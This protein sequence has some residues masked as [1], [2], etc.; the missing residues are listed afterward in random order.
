M[1]NR[2]LNRFVNLVLLFL[3]ILP[4]AS[5]IADSFDLIIDRY[6][7]LWAA[8]LCLLMWL[9][10]NFQ[11][12]FFPGLLLSALLIYLAYKA[13]PADLRLALTDFFDRITGVYYEHYYAIGSQ[14]P[15]ANAV[16]SHSF[17]LLLAVFL[18]SA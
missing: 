4:L 18:L 5:L 9:A 8:A 16:A 10:A 17:I 15:F 11:H 3:C 12:G 1:K 13:F 6:F 2:F 7:M 14:Y